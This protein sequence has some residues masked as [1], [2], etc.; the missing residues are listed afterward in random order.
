MFTLH[1]WVM[2]GEASAIKWRGRIQ[3]LRSGEVSNCVD[4]DSLIAYIEE[5]LHEQN[6]KSLHDS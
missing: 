6:N 4:W 2:H 1:I 3:N 5:T